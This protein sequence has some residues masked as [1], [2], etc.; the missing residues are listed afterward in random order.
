[1]DLAGQGDEAA[2]LL[3]D[4]GQVGRVRPQRLEYG[5]HGYVPV[6]ERAEIGGVGVAAVLAAPLG[7]LGPCLCTAVH[8][9]GPEGGGGADGGA[10]QH[11]K[12]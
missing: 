1:M 6:M 11:G 7:V 12:S 10:Q 2:S 9:R 8:D 5:V 3:V 4:V